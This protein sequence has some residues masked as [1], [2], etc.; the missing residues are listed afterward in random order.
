ME[1]NS[2]S[3]QEPE[4]DDN[5]YN[6]CDVGNT[7]GVKIKNRYFSQAQF[8]IELLAFVS[9]NSLTGYMCKVTRNADQTSRLVTCMPL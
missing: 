3:S 1:D 2:L 7:F 6:F 5:P 9:A 8:S 4:L